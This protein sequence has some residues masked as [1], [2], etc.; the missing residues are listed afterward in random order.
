MW[1]LQLAHFGQAP[2]CCL[3]FGGA[4]E[5]HADHRPEKLVGIDSVRQGY[6]EETQRRLT[7]PQ[8]EEEAQYRKDAWANTV[9]QCWKSWQ[10]LT[11]HMH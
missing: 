10:S 4:E 6:D 2:G 8:S 7:L 11:V 1:K 5:G 3:S 9:L